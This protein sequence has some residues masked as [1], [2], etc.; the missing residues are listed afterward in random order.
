MAF[1]QLQTFFKIHS[2]LEM[3]L[4]NFKAVH[5]IETVY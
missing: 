5:S 4:F 3:F 2:N 1:M